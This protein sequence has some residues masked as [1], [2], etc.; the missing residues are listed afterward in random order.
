MKFLLLSVAI[1]I[2]FASLAL[3]AHAADVVVQP[4]SGSGFVVK[5]ANGTNERLRVQES[6]AVN[7]PGVVTAPSQSQALCVGTTGQ[8]GP[9]SGGGS[10]GSSY[11]AGA[12][13]NLAGTT[14]S[15]APTY[16]LPQSCAANQVAQ[17]S[18]AAWI[19][20]SMGAYAAGTGLVLSGM[21][22]SVGPTY[23]LPQTCAANQ[24]P[25]WDG[26]TT[27]TCGSPAVNSLPAGTPNQTLRY[28]GSSALVANNLLQAFGDGGLVAGGTVGTGAI[29]ITGAGAR[30]MWYPARAAFRVGNVSASQWD[31]T[32]IG[33][34]SVA[35]G[36]NTVARGSSSMAMGSDADATGSYSTAMGQNS[37]A[38]GNYSTA[39]GSSATAVG[40][41]STALGFS[42]HTLSAY[43]TAMG[44]GTTAGA[45][46]GAGSSAVAMGQ[47]TVA[48]GDI[49]TAM[50]SATIASGP[51]STAMGSNV[52][53]AGNAG[54]FIYGDASTTRSQVTNT[55]P[56]QFVVAATGG[57]YFFTGCGTM[58]TTGVGLASGSGSWFSLSDRNAKTAVQ[59]VDGRE[60]LKKIASLPL[61]TWQ[62]K[63]QEAK[64]RHMGPMAQ[65]F[66]AAFHL[67]ESDKGIDT[68]DADGVALAAIQGLSALLTEKDAKIDA[69]QAE[70]SAQRQELAEQ[71][72]RVAALSSLA[73]QFA[74]MKAEMA[75]LRRSSPSVTTVVSTQP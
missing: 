22:F 18:G 75:A 11:S 3:S 58:C 74:E 35:M 29:P 60:V 49:S 42:T 65:D 71:K 7:L 12:G 13:L 6:G 31:D 14:F 27:W 8:L 52:S 44:N 5:D 24:I 33:N 37:Q 64:Y 16:Q 41:A 67:G 69:L 70:V 23:Q 68:V 72:E 43:S 38:I 21:S 55:A 25:I 34:F 15:V 10:G 30:L 20:G 63:T 36:N 1:T 39:I 17:W 9:C 59:P 57:V 45:P 40:T 19:C 28:D 26:S 73:S 62:Y 50:G 4:S 53:T 56:N 48:S 54:S 46:G 2:V 32:N 51:I 61:N 66:Y 47:G